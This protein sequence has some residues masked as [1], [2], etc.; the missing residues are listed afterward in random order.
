MFAQSEISKST[1]L[2]LMSR[3]GWCT[4]FAPAGHAGEVCGE[5]QRLFIAGWSNALFFTQ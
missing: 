4:Y 5:K 1:L 2:A 3:N